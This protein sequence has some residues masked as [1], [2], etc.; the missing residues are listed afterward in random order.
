[1]AAIYDGHQ[2][3]AMVYL[4][5]SFDKMPRYFLARMLHGKR[6][7]YLANIVVCFLHLICIQKIADDAKSRFSSNLDVPQGSVLF[8]AL[9][10]ISVHVLAV[11][12]SI[13][14]MSVCHSSATFFAD[15][16]I[17][18]ALPAP[19]LQMGCNTTGAARQN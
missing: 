3:I 9:Y 1:M 2:Y 8:L 13:V 12:L 11:S 7:E 5:K 10:K 14:P 17:L 15:D 4:K 6:P 18:G 19:G 16:V